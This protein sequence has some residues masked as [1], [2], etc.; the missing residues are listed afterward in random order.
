MRDLMYLVAVKFDRFDIVKPRMSRPGNSERYLVARGFSGDAGELATFLGKVNEEMNQ[1]KVGPKIAV[2][3]HK[4][5][6]SGTSVAE[7]I[8]LGLNGV[9]SL[10]IHENGEE[11]FDKWLRDV[12][13]EFL[14]RQVKALEDVRVCHENPT[15]PGYNSFE[16]TKQIYR[17]WGVESQGERRAQEEESNRSQREQER[18][19]DRGNG[20]GRGRDDR[21]QGRRDDRRDD[22]RHDDR[23]GD[24]R[25]GSKP[26]DRPT[27]NRR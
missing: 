5:S 26:Y 19:N 20:G 18:R 16:L 11:E 13:V 7:K 1:C 22:R 4:G 3:A 12:D 17:E 27:Q 21:G 25:R 10:I 15:A 24:D 23:R 9:Q 6:A 14:E 2:S 8:E